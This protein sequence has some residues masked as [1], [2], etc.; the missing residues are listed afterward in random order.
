MQSSN[1]DAPVEPNF[2]TV[3]ES[4]QPET[5]TYSDP[6][7]YLGKLP[8]ETRIMIYNLIVRTT[9]EQLTDAT[10]NAM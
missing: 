6:L 5:C 2:S 1:P 8:A 4:T 9:Q 7:G 10:E 3:P